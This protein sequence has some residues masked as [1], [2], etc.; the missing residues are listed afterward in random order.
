MLT[1]FTV[2]CTGNASSEEEITEA[3]DSTATEVM[4]AAQ[5]VVDTTA[6]EAES[7]AEEADSTATMN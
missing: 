4:D 6:I 1:L 5:E 7:P 2:A 3:V